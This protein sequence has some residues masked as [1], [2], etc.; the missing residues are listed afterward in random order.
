MHYAQHTTHHIKI[1]VD[2]WQLS[3]RKKKC[4]QLN[5]LTIITQCIYFFISLFTLQIGLEDILFERLKTEKQHMLIFLCCQMNVNYKWKKFIIKNCYTW[6]YDIPNKDTP[7]TSK[8]ANKQ[9]ELYNG[10]ISNWFCFQTVLNAEKI[11]FNPCKNDT[12]SLLY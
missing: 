3:L 9:Q 12:D 11:S 1:W 2:Q 6:G 10:Q 4:V 8:K 5:C 7:K